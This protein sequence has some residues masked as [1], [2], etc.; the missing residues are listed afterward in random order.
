V[1]LY[2]AK[3]AGVRGRENSISTLRVSQ[4]TISPIVN[5]ATN[6]KYAKYFASDSD[7][8]RFS[9]TQDGL[10]LKTEPSLVVPFDLDH[11]RKA[12][13]VDETE[14][15]NKHPLE[16]VGYRT[17]LEKVVVRDGEEVP[18]KVYHPIGR[19]T[20]SMPL[21]FVTHG[22]GWVQGSFITEEAW[23]LWALFPLKEFV[24]VSVEYRLAPE[25]QYPTYVNDSWDV[26]ENVVGRS[27]DLG[28]DVGHIFLAGSSAGGSLAAVLSQQAR[29]HDLKISGVILNV[30]VTCHPDYFPKD[31]YESTSYEQCFGT[32]LGSGEMRQ[33]WK[34]VMKPDDGAYWQASPLLGE[35]S[36]LP[37]HLVFVAGQDP[38]RDEGLAYA[39]KLEESGVQVTTQVY[40]GV[41]HTFAEFWEL[42]QTKKFQ[43]DLV[44]GVKKMLITN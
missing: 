19:E 29:E 16:D 39:V 22:G 25:H 40:Q 10:Q 28:F 21:L 23:L 41:P 2:P 15:A 42:E 3:I 44:D 37:P 13:V 11:D 9:K 8:E 26:L 43:A 18:I 33:V 30:P 24:I 31:K 12:Q 36:K 27:N 32:L 5:M 6:L 7:W 38:L 35:L 34:M 1:L 17:R 20:E 14:W 4:A